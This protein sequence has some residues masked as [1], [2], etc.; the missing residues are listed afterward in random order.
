MVMVYG[1]QRYC[2]RNELPNN[3]AIFSARCYAVTQLRS[4]AVTQLLLVFLRCDLREKLSILNIYY[5]IYIL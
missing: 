3:C 1:M 2:K 5:I 4:Y